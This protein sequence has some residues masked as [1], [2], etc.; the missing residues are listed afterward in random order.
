[1]AHTLDTVDRRINEIRDEQAEGRID[2]YQARDRLIALDEE[3]TTEL[4]RHFEEI[5]DHVLRFVQIANETAEA[6]ARVHYIDV[7]HDGVP[8]LEWYASC[9]C[10]WMGDRRNI[11]DESIADG[12]THLDAMP[13][14]PW[15]P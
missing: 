15:R 3:R 14:G 2:L 8:T 12:H 10:G 6:L 7:H 13:E 4:A 1:M 5:P 9:T 11:A